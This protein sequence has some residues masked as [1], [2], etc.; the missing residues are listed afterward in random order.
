MVEVMSNGTG[1]A[2]LEVIEKSGLIPPAV[3]TQ[4]IGELE[5]QLG[6][7]ARSDGARLLE[8][9]VA[10]ELLT[11]WQAG[12]LRQGKHK[13]F[14]LG[15]YKLLRHLGSGGMSSVYLAEHVHM[16]QL[17]ALKVL[18][19][20]RVNDASYLARFYREARAAAA[21]DHPN[22]VHAYD[23]ASDGDTHFLVVE[24]IDG[25]DLQQLVG[26]KGPL[27][28]AS[29]IDVVR[30]AA[31]GLAHAHDVGVVH[32]DIKPA[33]L[34]VDNEGTVKILDMGLARFTSEEI[35]QQ[36]SLTQMND[37]QV[38]GTTNYLSPEQA[39]DSHAVDG[40]ADIYSLGCTFYFLL[41]ASPPFST[42]TV[43]QR[44]MMHLQQKPA[45]ISTRRRGVPPELEAIFEKMTAKKPKQRYQSAAEVEAIFHQLA[46]RFTPDAA[47]S[48][49]VI[50]TSRKDDSAR[51]R[52]K[53]KGMTF[54]GAA[55]ASR[56]SAAMRDTDGGSGG[57]TTAQE[58]PSPA[59]DDELRLADDDAP[60]PNRD[61]GRSR[62]VAAPP[63]KGAAADSKAAA[64]PRRESESP[65]ATAAGASGDPV[66]AARHDDFLAELMRAAESAGPSTGTVPTPRAP[67]PTAMKP[68]ARSNPSAAMP[69]DDDISV[70]KDLDRLF[71]RH[72][73][74]AT[75]VFGMF[76]VMLVLGLYYMIRSSTD[77]AAPATTTGASRDH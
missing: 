50:E 14:L 20:E 11:S 33:N 62:T 56:E 12:K 15:N 2:L 44:L 58:R 46:E 17:R 5:S 18:P 8:R 55:E 48:G 13:G 59:A 32:R 16:K 67:A 27:S 77:A 41:T 6:T 31:A 22:I 45:P 10:A 42:G 47:D 74:F 1:E 68:A 40:R 3:L 61:P 64:P 43:A 26:R 49:L 71:G 60:K 66:I 9:L 52:A 35:E 70:K 36:A 51:R 39:I 30:Q 4:A 29:A 72:P 7:D 24:Y 21:L 63:A 75:I 28:F 57:P 23:I 25:S 34:F 54:V 38:L 37:E 65:V 73:A 53:P 69:T 76:A 19:R